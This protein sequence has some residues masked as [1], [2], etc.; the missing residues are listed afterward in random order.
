L[1]KLNQVGLLLAAF[2]SVVLA[3]YY[4]DISILAGVGVFALIYS[5]V[6]LEYKLRFMPIAFASLTFI[7]GC[8][9]LIVAPWLTQLYPHANPDYQIPAGRI[10]D[11]LSYSAPLCMALGAGLVVAEKVSPGLR[12]RPQ[13]L[14][15]INLDKT[16]EKGVKSLFW[17][18]F[19]LMV[20]S[21][22]L[23]IPGGLAFF[24]L[25]VSE[26]ALVCPLLL[27]LG[28]CP[29]WWKYALL[30]MGWK[31]LSSVG[32]TVFHT[33]LLWAAAYFM[34][35]WS[36]RFRGRGFK[37]VI[38]SGLL[39][40]MIFQPAKTF[41]RESGAGG[42]GGFAS[43]MG[44]F[45]MHPGQA[46]TDK[47]LSETL[48]RLNQGWIVYRVMDWVPRFEP[49]AGFSIIA[50]Q[51]GG[52]FLPRFI[53]PDKFVA[54]GREHFEQYTGHQ[55]FDASMGLGYAGEFYAAFG[56][57]G[58]IVAGFVYGLLL[59]VAFNRLMVAARANPLWWAWG[60]FLF[61]VAIKAED[62]VGNA[63]N[64]GA[65]AYMVVL[66]VLFF[67]RRIFTARQNRPPARRVPSP[68]HQRLAGRA[69]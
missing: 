8:L 50:R 2:G 34:F 51:F 54:G 64:W 66:L 60:P 21:S 12:G 69:K 7:T 16:A 63:I 48:M 57:G 67:Y 58:G 55:L 41:I 13:A 53:M 6:N 17:S 47:N 31:L 19:V 46:Y 30:P 24:V 39:L 59:G 65:K 20:I 28:R 9:Q 11:Y 42:I 25:L 35:Y 44:D 37:N 52:V 18:T 45:L 62:T 15:R 38:F 14:S 29:L 26:I 23:P 33:F 36:I 10:A 43:V 3:P 1:N 32:S 56:Y 40:V 4:A 49:Y 5:A 22:S 61:L 27:Y 68:V